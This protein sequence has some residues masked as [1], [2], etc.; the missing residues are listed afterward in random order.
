MKNFTLS[1]VLLFILAAF[2]TNA[3]G[4][5][6]ALNTSYTGNF[7]DVYFVSA[8]TGFA[9]GGNNSTGVVYKTTNGG[10]SWTATTIPGSSLESV[11][12]V[13]SSTGYIAGTNGKVYKTTNGGSSWLVQNTGTTVH[14]KSVQF[15]IST[16]GFAAGGT[17]LIKTINSSSSWSSITLPSAGSN[18]LSNGAFFTTSSQGVVY[19]SYN[20]FNGWIAYTSNG[21]T[22][23]ALPVYT[24]PAAINDV[25]FPSA[26]VGYAVGNAGWIYKTTNGGSSW[27]SLSSGTTKN[28]NGVFFFDNNTGFAVGDSGL[29][30]KTTNGGSSWINQS[31]ATVF[32]L[33]D[34]F[35]ASTS[36]AYISGDNNKIYK[37]TSG[38]TSLS[39]NAPDDS[40]YCNG[41]T[42]LHAYVTYNGTGTISYSWTP[43]TGLSSTTDSVVTAGPLTASMTYVVTVTDGTLTASDTVH[44]DVVP[45]PPD[46]ICIVA[47]DSVSNHPIVVFEKHVS[48]PIDYYK[49]Y[50]ESNVAGIYDSIGFIPADTAG[51]F[52][53]SAANVI[54]RAYSYKI[55]SVDSC[56]NESIMS[57]HHKTMH[58]QVNQGA[59]NNWN[60]V[61]TPYEGLFIQSYQIWRGTDTINMALIGTVPG[62]NTSYTDLNPPTGGLYY[63]VRIISAYTCQPYNYKAQTNY[64]TSR[65]NRANNGLTNPTLAA[66]F[67]ASPTSGNSPLN[68]QFTDNTN[69][70]PTSWHWEFGDGDTSNQQSPQHTYTADGKYSVKLVVSNSNSSDSITKTDFITVGSIGFEDIDSEKDIRIYPN[71][72]SNG[73]SL[74]IDY[75]YV[76]IADIEMLD[77]IGKQV[78]CDISRQKGHIEI[79]SGDLTGG[80]Y[81]LKLK[82][83]TGDLLIRKVI[84]R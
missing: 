21:G 16:T 49:I 42:N 26:S 7:K 63:M 51:V 3:Q 84:V 35:A 31:I 22:S 39:V 27:T 71:P 4:G 12:F 45:L 5:W 20:F 54:V 11:W 65:S 82:S 19:G 74:I 43:S 1:L 50:R 48:G 66:N 8:T 47:V 72:L 18:T 40:V 25:Y 53:D 55:T 17:T 52:V 6:I 24:T 83:D 77:I 15:P 29:I 23:W 37:T 60:L 62:S 34:V 9:V 32:P 56:G 70:I 76:N 33:Q 78:N 79:K 44:V 36:I 73:Q 67:T 13:N 58:L 10:S 57:A 30:M 2:D 28:F 64:H 68:V 46:S 75:K 81:I 61:W 59:G 41:Y 14:F 69:G 80:V 38:G